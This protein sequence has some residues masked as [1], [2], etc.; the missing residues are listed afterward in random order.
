MPLFDREK[1]VRL[2]SEL[3]K[4]V[5]RLHA[6]RTLSPDQFQSD[7]DKVGSAKYHLIVAIETCIDMCNHLISRNGYRVPEDYGDTFKVMTE[8]G[9]L[10]ASFSEDLKKMVKFRNRLVHLYWQVDDKQVYDIIQ[11]RLDDFK[12][13]LDSMSRFLGWHDLVSN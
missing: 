11:D 7:P 3:R 13:F 8:A 6:L 1:M 9:A 10:D 4:S 2:S 5:Q 12:R